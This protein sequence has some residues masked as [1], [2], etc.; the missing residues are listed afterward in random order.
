MGYERDA[1]PLSHQ[2]VYP[3]ASNDN[4]K[5]LIEQHLLPAPSNDPKGKYSTSW[6]VW[7]LILVQIP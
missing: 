4:P 7:V 6:E 1:G 5:D 3:V 2:E